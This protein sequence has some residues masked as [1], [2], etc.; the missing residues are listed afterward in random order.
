MLYP[1]LLYQHQ[2]ESSRPHF[3]HQRSVQTYIRD[4][5]PVTSGSPRIACSERS[6]VK[7]GEVNVD[8]DHGCSSPLDLWRFPAEGSSVGSV[9][10]DDDI[11]EMVLLHHL[12]SLISLN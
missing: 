6:H 12:S 8:F 1:S 11:L 5:S 10:T 3:T 7:G 2:V 9:L 4:N